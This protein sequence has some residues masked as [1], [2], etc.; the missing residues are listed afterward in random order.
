VSGDDAVAEDPRVRGTGVGHAIQDE[1]IELDE[2]ARIQQQLQPFARGELAQR[3]LAL[4]PR[5]ATS[6][7]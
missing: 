7:E 6:Q 5:G 4:D 1:G 3:M 2:R